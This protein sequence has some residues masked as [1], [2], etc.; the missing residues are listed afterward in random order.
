MPE[1]S[2]LSPHLRGGGIGGHCCRDRT[3]PITTTV[4]PFKVYLDSDGRMN[5]RLIALL[6][7]EAREEAGH[8]IVLAARTENN[9]LGLNTLT[10]EVGAYPRKAGRRG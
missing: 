2:L 5:L 3:A 8:E 4:L 6:P 9:A 1:G 7:H 10:P